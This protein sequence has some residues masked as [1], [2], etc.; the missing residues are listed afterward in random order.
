[1]HACAWR[2][3]RGVQNREHSMADAK[4]RDSINRRRERTKMVNEPTAANPNE[5]PLDKTYEESAKAAE[6]A[7]VEFEAARADRDKARAD[8]ENK[9]RTSAEKDR[10]EAEQLRAEAK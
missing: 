4:R 10:T 2:L 7:R 5:A 6:Q 8:A 3:Q 9:W 1:M